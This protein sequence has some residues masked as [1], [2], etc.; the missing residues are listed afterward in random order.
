MPRGRHRHSPPLHRL[1]PPSAIAGVSLVCALGPWVFTQPRCSACSPRPPRR[2]RSSARSSCAA[3]TSQAGKQVADLTRA[4]AERR[5]AHEERVAELESDLEES[6]ELRGQAGAAAAGQARRAG[7]PAQ[8]ARARCC[9]G[10]PPA[11]TERASALEGR[12]LLEIEAAP[13]PARCRPPADAAGAEETDGVRRG[14]AD[15]GADAIEAVEADGADGMPGRR[16][17]RRIPRSFSPAGSQLFLRAKAALE[18]LDAGGR[19]SGEDGTEATPRPPTAPWKAPW[20]LPPRA[21][22]E[23][24]VRRPRPPADALPEPSCR[25]HERPGEPG[26]REGRLSADD[27]GPDGDGP[28]RSRPP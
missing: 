13:Q 14:R 18:R 23:R 2:R 11:E 19:G 17:R 22:P 15:A 28:P 26:R 24:R 25:G 9:A 6:R 27:D 1:L 8:R 16:R 20:R 5:V 12:R 21:L 3:G 7:G 4:R 10:T